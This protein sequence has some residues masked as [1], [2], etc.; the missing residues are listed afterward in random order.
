M[1]VLYR[2]REKGRDLFD[3]SFLTGVAAPDFEYNRK[4]GRA[5]SGGISP[6]L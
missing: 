1:T 4:D 2:K 3:V 5:E 6:T